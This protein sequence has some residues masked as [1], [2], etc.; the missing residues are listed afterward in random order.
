MQ[1][2]YRRPSEYKWS[3]LG[4]IQVVAQDLPGCPEKR[5]MVSAMKACTDESCLCSRAGP[6]RAIFSFSFLPVRFCIL[7]RASPL[8]S[9]VK[10]KR[11]WKL[12]DAIIVWRGLFSSSKVIADA[13]LRL[14]VSTKICS[15]NKTLLFRV[16]FFSV[17]PHKARW[18]ACT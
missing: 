18:A 12:R 11:N 16:I 13:G 8:Q 17:P 1:G 15:L 14:E 10:L 6:C 9:D 4:M 5:V 3:L 7:C 2:S